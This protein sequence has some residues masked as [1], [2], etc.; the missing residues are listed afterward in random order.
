MKKIF[1]LC[2]VL[3][4]VNISVVNAASF[5][6]AFKTPVD[7]AHRTAVMGPY[8]VQWLNSRY[9]LLTT[10]STEK[11]TQAD[12]QQ[13][14]QQ[15]DRL[16]A[17]A[18]TI[19]HLNPNT[20]FVIP[21]NELVV[22]DLKNQFEQEGTDVEDTQTDHQFDNE[23]RGS[24]DRGLDYHTPEDGHS[25]SVGFGDQDQESMG[26]VTDK[27]SND[28]DQEHADQAS[29]DEDQESTQQSLDN[30]SDDDSQEPKNY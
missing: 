24:A 15:S 16:L 25:G 13:S 21:V 27:A 2:V 9:V 10:K 26:Q 1:L 17:E 20:I 14:F 5:F 4:I 8:S 12:N 7:L 23:N 6:A 29:G 18:R 28:E 19:H 3:I 11:Q 22:T 30:T